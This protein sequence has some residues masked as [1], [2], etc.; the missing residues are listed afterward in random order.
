M[1]QFLFLKT[2]FIATGFS[3]CKLNFLRFGNWIYSLVIPAPK[4]PV[5]LFLEDKNIK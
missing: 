2:I 3:T 5:L 1:F 4:E